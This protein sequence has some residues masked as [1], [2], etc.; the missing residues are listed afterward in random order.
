MLLI[1]L[2]LATKMARDATRRRPFPSDR[3]AVDRRLA[4]GARADQGAHDGT[5]PQP[6]R[7]REEDEEVPELRRANTQEARRM[8]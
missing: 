8:A 4:F 3:D 1:F 7:G 2:L 5:S 6:A